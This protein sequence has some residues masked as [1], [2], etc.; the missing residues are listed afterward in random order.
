MFSAVTGLGGAGGG[1]TKPANGGV[2]AGAGVEV[3]GTAK[4]L[5]LGGVDA[6]LGQSA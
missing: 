5:I 2:G 3:D 4:G 6:V 1:A